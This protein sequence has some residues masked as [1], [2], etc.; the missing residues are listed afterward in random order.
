MKKKYIHF[1]LGGILTKD[2]IYNKLEYLLTKIKKEN[3]NIE[4]IVKKTA[5]KYKN[6]NFIYQKHNDSKTVHQIVQA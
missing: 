3:E 1:P 5:Q 2:I 6:I 4:N